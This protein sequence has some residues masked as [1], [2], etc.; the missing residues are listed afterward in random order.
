MFSRFRFFFC[1]I[2]PVLVLLPFG[3]GMTPVHTIFRELS[4]TP[5]LHPDARRDMR[6]AILA[7][8]QAEKLLGEIGKS[9]TIADREAL[10]KRIRFQL[11]K[12]AGDL[13]TSRAE[14]VKRGQGDHP[15]YAA[16]EKRLAELESRFANEKLNLE[17]SQA[18]ARAQV[19]GIAAE[20][21]ALKA[22]YDRL[23]KPLFSRATGVGLYFN[24]LEPVAELLKAIEHFEKNDLDRLRSQL[25]S[26]RKKAGPSSEEID[27]KAKAD[28]WKD[29]Y[30]RPS[31][32]VEKLEEAIVNIAKTRQVMAEELIKKANEYKELVKTGSADFVRVER[33]RWVQEHLEFAVKFDPASE[34]AKAE[35]A[36]FPAWREAD[37]KEFG[38]TI[39]ARKF[40][41][42]RKA[43]GNASSLEKTAFTWFAESHDWGRRNLSKTAKDREPRR[44]IRVAV[45]GPWTVQARNITGQ[46]TMHGIPVKLVVALESEKELNVYR[47]YE[48]TLRTAERVGIKAAP[49]FDSVTVGNSYYIRPKAVR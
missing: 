40:P 25:E 4:G 39:D 29:T 43:P 47:V 46:I 13:K 22:E 12:A 30:H 35:L 24:D 1:F 17:K 37:W 18:G 44:V 33:T 32:A 31:Y 49:P 34:K 9:P 27:R 6:T 21:M 3:L 42:P 38:K 20:A 16:T 23:Y 28:G 19:A 41:G 45:M 5:N 15:E 8:N 2:I 11:D 10:I 26:F 36:A 14:A 7:L 48:L